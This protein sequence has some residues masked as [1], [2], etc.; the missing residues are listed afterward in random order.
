VTEDKSLAKSTIEAVKKLHENNIGFTITSSRPAFGMRMLIEPLGL[1]LPI[2]AFNGSSIVDPAFEIIQQHTIPEGAVVTSIEMLKQCGVDVWLF[3][4][5]HWLIARDDGFYVPKERK[6]IQTNPVI[7]EGFSEFTAHTCKVVGVSAE[8]DKL[9]RC[10]NVLQCALEREA[11]V[12]RSQSYYLDITPV[13][14]SKG[15]FV[16]T[17][18]ERFNVPVQHVATIGD[19][20]NDLP[21][22][23]RSG[24]SFAMGNATDEVK[25][26][27]TYVT[28]SNNNDGFAKAIEVILAG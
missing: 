5:E 10:E 26:K 2:G 4:N 13:G 27:A 19:M 16:D 24:V 14:L 22:F 12:V 21:M 20:R 1:K 25:S 8:P 7:R 3:T 28:E 15:T 9:E 17:I 18:A 23:Q 6:T 11:T